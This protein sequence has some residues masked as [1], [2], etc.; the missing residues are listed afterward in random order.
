MA[1]ERCPKLLAAPELVQASWLNAWAG[2]L[3]GAENELFHGVFLQ[4]SKMFA[5]CF[6]WKSAN[7]FKVF[8]GTRFLIA[9]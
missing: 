9:F 5:S 8:S 2:E 1:A 4:I 7:R 6:L 3:F